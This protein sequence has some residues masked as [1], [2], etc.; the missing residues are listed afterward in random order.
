[1]SGRTVVKR[2]RRNRGGATPKGGRFAGFMVD[3]QQEAFKQAQR[4]AKRSRRLLRP[5]ADDAKVGTRGK[6][7]RRAAGKRQRQAR[8]RQHKLARR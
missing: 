8:A 5:D 4:A 7:A 1:M 3:P 2:A 6:K